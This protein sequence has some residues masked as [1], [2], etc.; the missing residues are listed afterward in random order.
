MQSGARAQNSF[1]GDL[2]DIAV[3][4]F[5]KLF[6]SQESVVEQPKPPVIKTTPAKPSIIDLEAIPDNPKIVLDLSD[7]PTPEEEAKERELAANNRALT[8]QYL[9]KLEVDPEESQSIKMQ[10]SVKKG[11]QLISQAYKKYHQ[12]DKAKSLEMLM[13]LMEGLGK[14]ASQRL[15]HNGWLGSAEVNRYFELLTN[16]QADVYHIDSGDNMDIDKFQASLKKPGNKRADL[17]RAANRMFWPICQ[18]S[19]WYLIMMEK[20]KD[21]TYNVSCLDSLGWSDE[22]ITNKAHLVLKALYPSKDVENLVNKTTRIPVP[23]QN[24]FNDCGVSAC[25]WGLQLIKRKKLPKKASGTCDYSQFRFDIAETFVKHAAKRK[26]NEVIVIE[27]DEPA[28]GK[29]SSAIV[30]LR[31][32]RFKKNA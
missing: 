24:N 15:L 30:Q 7:D 6:G 12:G 9:Q 20:N 2:F 11:Y 22:Q 10:G 1:W 14:E 26:A 19:H 32:K 23:Q 25:Y 4:A 3:E 16:E 21:Q 5:Q 29:S 8:Y 31:N 28:Q 18:D 13:S 27:D 17:M